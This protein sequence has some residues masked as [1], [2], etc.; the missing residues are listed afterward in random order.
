[1]ASLKL[2]W[3]ID[4]LLGRKGRSKE[5]APAPPAVPDGVRVYVIGDIHGRADLLDGL[6]RKIEADVKSAEGE[7][8]TLFLG[9]YVDRGPASAAV[10]DR[11]C[12]GDFPTRIATLRGNHEQMLLAAFEGEEI[13]ASWR[14]YGGL[15][16]LASYGVDVSQAMRGVGYDDVRARLIDRAPVEHRKF[17]EALPLAHELGD[18]FFC[19]AGVRPGVALA[20]QS[21]EDLLWIRD[22]FLASDAFHGKVIVHGHTPAS[23]PEV[24]PNRINVDTGAYATGVLTCLALEGTTR[25]FLST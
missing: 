24:R 19:H 9:D 17:L 10:L 7:A 21:A 15:E 11:L 6:A 5:L 20:R 3:S 16:T 18:Y 8:T 23:A 4:R 22:D 14:Q 12:K 25:R 1:L 13:F 2:G